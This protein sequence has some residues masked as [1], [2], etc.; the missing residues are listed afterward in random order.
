MRAGLF[1]RV[2]GGGGWA[3][4]RVQA[5]AVCAEG[6]VAGQP[7][8]GIGRGQVWHGQ[9][10]RPDRASDKIVLL[11]HIGSGGE[12]GVGQ[13]FQRRRDPGAS[14]GAGRGAGQEIWVISG[15]EWNCDS[16]HWH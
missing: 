12:G 15:S 5:N 14:I 1:V 8:V 9:K 2:S 16:R 3:R 6:A 13:E 4:G 10:G 11:P 7:G